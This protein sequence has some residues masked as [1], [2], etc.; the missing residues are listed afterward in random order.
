MSK[1]LTTLLNDEKIIQRFVQAVPRHVDAGRFIRACNL[2][3]AS[4][5]KLREANP[6][7]VVGAM[8]SIASIGL[9]P[10]NIFGHAYIIP[11]DDRRKG[12]VQPTVQIGYKGLMDLGQRSGAVLKFQP[13]IVYEN[14]FFDYELGLNEKLVHKPSQGERGRPIFGYCIAPL[15]NGEK[16]WNVWSYSQLLNARKF[17]K[18]YQNKGQNSIW[19]KHEEAMILKTTIRWL[20]N[21]IPKNA[22]LAMATTLDAMS[23]RQ[24]INFAPIVDMHL[25]DVTPQNVVMEVSRILESEPKL[26]DDSIYD[27]ARE[28]AI[29]EDVEKK[30]GLNNVIEVETVVTEPKQN[31]ADFDP[32][33]GE[34]LEG[35]FGLPPVVETSVQSEPTPTQE[36]EP[37]ID[38]Q[39]M[40]AIV[41]S[42]KEKI[43]GALGKDTL[44]GR[45]A[46]IKKDG[47]FLSLSEPAQQAVIAYGQERWK[48]LPAQDPTFQG[49]AT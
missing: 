18:E 17:S 38:Y 31:P 15:Q 33:T 21:L 9:E 42:L 1:Q 43:D 12:I 28:K 30:L 6:V 35:D 44:K 20:S 3:V 24:K 4:N 39:A 25:D 26:E 13:Q 16:I 46:I 8:L 5:Q 23:D 2:A 40:Q 49:G 36:E 11:F 27:P 29:S 41:D 47:G 32:E 10:G 37:E 7:D 45:M 19:G 34:I 48:K 14:D 22:E